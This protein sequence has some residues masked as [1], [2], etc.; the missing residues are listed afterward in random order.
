MIGVR[1]CVRIQSSDCANRIW[2]NNERW[3]SSFIVTMGIF[4]SNLL[5]VSYRILYYSDKPVVSYNFAISGQ[6]CFKPKFRHNTGVT[7]APCRQRLDNTL[8]TLVYIAVTTVTYDEDV[9]HIAFL[10]ILSFPTALCLFNERLCSISQKLM[11]QN[12]GEGRR[13]VKNEKSS[14]SLF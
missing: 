12:N 5:L 1:R 14:S 4:I 2:Q 8:A 11:L 9:M 3:Y 10:C 6:K 7:A 13:A